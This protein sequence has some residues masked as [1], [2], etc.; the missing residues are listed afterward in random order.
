MLRKFLFREHKEMK[1]TLE[2]SKIISRRIFHTQASYNVSKPL[3]GLEEWKRS[4]TVIV[5]K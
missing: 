1:I 5:Y 3:K 2:P 4:M